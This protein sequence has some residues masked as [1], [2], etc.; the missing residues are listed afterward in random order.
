MEVKFVPTRFE[1][2]GLEQATVGSA[3]VD[4][5][6]PMSVAIMP[7]STVIV[8]M[9]FKMEIPEGHA[10]LIMPRSG[11]A[12]KLGVTISN[13]P[14]L[15]DSDY[16]GE[17]RVALYNRNSFVMD[18]KKGERVAQ[19]MIIPALQFKM[20]EVKELSDTERGEGGFGSTGV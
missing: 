14:G 3:A 1:F 5:A 19:M 20:T 7:M 8:P 12:S 16:R 17:V 18:L 2:Q 9:G 13:S 6:L 15:I 11:M 4:L 10:A